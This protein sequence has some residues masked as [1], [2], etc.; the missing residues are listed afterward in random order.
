VTTP[1]RHDAHP[2]AGLLV[3]VTSLATALAAVVLFVANDPEWSTNQWYFAVDLTNAVVYG[4]VAW[5][6]LHRLR[7]PV[8]WV[9]AVTGVGGGLAALSF[10]WTKYAAAHPDGEQLRLLVTAQQWAWI[11]GFV[12]LKAVVPWLVRSGPLDRPAR[13]WVA[14]G[15]LAMTTLLTIRVLDPW[16]PWSDENLVW[17]P[18]FVVALGYIAA[19]DVTRRWWNGRGTDEGRGLGWLSLGLVLMTTAFLPLALPADQAARL[20]VWFS[21]ALS[22]LSEPIFPAAVLVVVLGQR[23]WGIDL[24]VSRTVVWSL[25]TGGVAVAY[26]GAVAVLTPLFDRDGPAQMLA[27]ALVVLGFQPGRVW[28]QRRVDGLVH[29][30][31]TGPLRTF[32]RVSVHLGSGGTE[33][34]VLTSVAGTLATSL[35]LG[36]VAIWAPDPA[37][38]GPRLVAEV[39]EPTGEEVTIDLGDRH[40]EVGRLVVTARPG[41]RLDG[42]ARSSLDEI[43]PLVAATLQLAHTRRAL[44]ASRRRLADARDEERRV[45]R[46][47]LHDGLGPA[48]AGVGLGL[49]AV[50][51][52]LASSS[53]AAAAPLLDELTAEL[54]R[55]VEEV[56]GLARG[57]LPPSLGGAGLAEALTE[58]GRRYAVT[59]LD[60]DVDVR[61]GPLPGPGSPAANA[62]YAIVAEAVRNVHRHAGARRCHVLLAVDG[63]LHVTVADDGSG[64]DADAS[65]GVGVASMRERAE[66]LGGTFRLESR[67]FNG[68]RVEVTVPA[69]ALIEELVP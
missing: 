43:A 48:L 68:T 60:V 50:H 11:P 66:G 44:L 61:G 58:L 41:E 16:I 64:L 45:L 59:G 46:R 3:L 15:L 51:N 31:G 55:R 47:E 7:H 56:R 57:L 49:Q 22:L 33:H 2:V 38:G 67:P 6:M 32:R 54:E 26:L 27:T 18:R 19:A 23:L 30:D 13:A 5:L 35:R 28:L 4:V 36:S 37:G 24:A 62:V 10:E 12:A 52:Q 34:D 20:P 14:I 42:R 65:A 9:M 40:G 21:P 53:P 63:D 29:G 25:L 69:T 1:G 8:A 17:G 39:G